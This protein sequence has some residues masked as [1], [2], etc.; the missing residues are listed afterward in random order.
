MYAPKKIFKVLS[1]V[2]VFSSLLVSVCL[3][4]PKL[5]TTKAAAKTPVKIQNS[6]V[7]SSTAKEAAKTPDKIQNI[8]VKTPTDEEAAK[9]PDKI[10]GSETE[11]P[12]ARISEVYDK[13]IKSEPLLIIIDKSKYK[14]YLFKAGKVLKSY[15]V[16]LGKNSGQKQ[17]VGDMT[18]PTGDFKID[19]IIDSSYWTHDFND[20][21]GEIEG[22]Y[23]PWFISLET[24]W[25]GIGIHGTHDP[26]SIK[27]MASEG[28][29][30]MNNDQ[31]AELK[32]LITIGTKVV[33]TI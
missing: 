27:T 3:A 6:E 29:I 11:P 30:R 33:I 4:T 31:V 10:L 8:E 20:G 14:L 13:I 32:V 17:R 15:D 18:T 21:N 1:L 25:D 22:A 26:S 19:E 16:A 12:T 7:K 28:C 24:G 23:G 2:L 5:P 9:A